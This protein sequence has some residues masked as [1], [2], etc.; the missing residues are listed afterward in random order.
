MQMSEIIV[1]GAGVVGSAIAF[2]LAKRH[3]RVLVLDGDRADFRASR[4]NFGLVW[5]QGKGEGLP[6][7]QSITQKSAL[8]WSDFAGQ[9]NDVAKTPLAL[10]QDGGLI[11][12]LSD[13]EWD[14]RLS[15]NQRLAE[16]Q[17]NRNCDTEMLDRA[18]LKRMLP[19]A[20]LG[21]EVVG[22]SFGHLDGAVNPLELLAGL[23][24]AIVRLGGRIEFQSPVKSIRPTSGGFEVHSGTETYAASKIVLAAGLSTSELALSLEMNVPLR[25]QRGQILVTERLDR[26]LPLPGSGLRQTREG[27]IMIGATH[28]DVGFNVETS[29]EAAAQLARRATRILPALKDATIVRQWSGLRVLSADGY[30][31][32]AQSSRYPGAFSASCHSGITLAAFHANE[33]ADAISRTSLDGMF[34]AF[35]PERFDVQE[36][37]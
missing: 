34:E 15:K 30:P 10:E 7:Y 18:S 19:N 6:A 23:H 16:Q 12:C 17:P 22:A 14:A 26:I 1:V 11:Y 5:V 4:A 35:T 37:A 3:H 31:I 28:E 21:P 9:L 2:G 20:E 32:Y 25:P 36:H 13:D 27:T 29:S 33:L 24:S 8:D